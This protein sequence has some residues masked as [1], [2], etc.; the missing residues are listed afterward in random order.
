VRLD[1]LDVSV[2]GVARAVAGAADAGRDHA[3]LGHRAHH[4]STWRIFSLPRVRL[5]PT[6]MRT[7]MR[8]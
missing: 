6:G 1:E 4:S 2:A 3:H 7:F 5:V 8:M